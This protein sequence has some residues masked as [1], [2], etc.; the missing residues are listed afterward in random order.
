MFTCYCFGPVKVIDGKSRKAHGSQ[1]Q[2]KGGGPVL[3]SI[4]WIAEANLMLLLDST[5]NLGKFIIPA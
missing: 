5:E 1:R 3:V 2:H 4:L